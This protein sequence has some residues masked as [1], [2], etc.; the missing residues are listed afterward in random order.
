[1]KEE[2]EN[3]LYLDNPTN[4]DDISF[5]IL[6]S[7]NIKER[8]DQIVYS[9]EEKETHLERNKE[10]IMRITSLTEELRQEKELRRK[11]ESNYSPNIVINNNIIAK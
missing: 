7:P 9:K 5:N 2:L 6:T 3:S 10:L 4:P 11:S 8:I 1:M